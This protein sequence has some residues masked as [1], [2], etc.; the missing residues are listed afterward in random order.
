MDHHPLTTILGPKKGIPPIATARMYRWALQLSAYQYDI[1]YKSTK[2]HGNADALSRLP[3]KRS[4]PDNADLPSVFNVHQIMSLPVSSQKVARTSRRD[5][6]ISKVLRYTRNGWPEEI[7]DTLKPY[8]Q[9]R[10]ELTTEGDTLLWGTRVVIPLPLRDTIL[11]DLH[12]GHPGIIRMKAIARS[13]LWWPGLD[14]DLEKL[15]KSCLPCQAVKQPPPPAPLHPWVWPT[16]PWQRIHIDFAGPFLGKMF[17][18][19]VDAHSKWAEVY[20]MTQTTSA[21]TIDVLR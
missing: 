11:K 21:K 1:E 6:V 9:R 12:Q 4:D 8:Y 20:E 5:A 15:A 14:G 3:L 13:Y 19:V 2:D 10:S 18:L 16:K 17:F 7:P